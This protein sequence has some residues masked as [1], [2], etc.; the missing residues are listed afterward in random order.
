M[1]E[2]K[3]I[4][5]EIPTSWKVSFFICLATTLGLLIGG[6]LLPPP[7]EIDDSVFKG[8]FIISIYPTLFT[9]FICV[10]RGMR[11][12]YD[13]KEGKIT[14][15]TKRKATEENETTTEESNEG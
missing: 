12:H 11:V 4:W 13:I 9:V 3:E 1:Q 10:L 8:C 7:G 2:F 5:K 6:F 14:V 15:N